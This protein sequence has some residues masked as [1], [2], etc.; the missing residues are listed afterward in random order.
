MSR[1]IIGRRTGTATLFAFDEGQGR[2]EHTAPFGA[3][4]HVTDG[5]AEVTVTRK[6][7]RLKEGEIVVM[8]AKKP[9]AIKAITKFR[10][11]LIMIRS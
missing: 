11:L 9:H 10:M 7:S 1:E 8:P 6:V 2:S 3:M 5:E 4:I